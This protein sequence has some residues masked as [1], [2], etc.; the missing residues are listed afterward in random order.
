MVGVDNF[1]A[2]LKAQAAHAGYLLLGEH[3]EGNTDSIMPEIAQNVNFQWVAGDPGT[4]IDSE[5]VAST[6]FAEPDWRR[7]PVTSMGCYVFGGLSLQSWER[8]AL[9]GPDHP[10]AAF[11]AGHRIEDACQSIF[12]KNWN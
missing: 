1:V 6:G 11:Q 4:N 3:S 7:R 8:W 5:M 12:V 2:Y 9:M 10:G